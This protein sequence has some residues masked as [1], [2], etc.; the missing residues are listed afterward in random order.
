[1]VWDVL[2][3]GAVAVMVEVFDPETE[4]KHQLAAPMSKGLVILP[5]RWIEGR[6][7]DSLKYTVTVL[8]R[9]REPVG[10]R[11]VVSRTK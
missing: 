4:E 9:D 5:R 2:G 11:M 3:N 6:D 8:G 7:V 1:M 10:D